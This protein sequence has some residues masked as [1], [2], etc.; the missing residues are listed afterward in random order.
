MCLVYTEYIEKNLSDYY[1]VCLAENM[2]LSG[3]FLSGDHCNSY[4]MFNFTMR[5]IPKIIDIEGKVE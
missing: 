2:C 1:S 3:V 5:Y 4:S